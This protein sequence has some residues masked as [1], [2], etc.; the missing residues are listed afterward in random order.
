MTVLQVYFLKIAKKWGLRN[1]HTKSACFFPLYVLLTK[2]KSCY[3]LNSCVYYY[4][5]GNLNA[6]GFIFLFT[7]YVAAII[8][9]KGNASFQQHLDCLPKHMLGKKSKSHSSLLKQNDCRVCPSQETAWADSGPDN[10]T[11][12][13]AGPGLRGPTREQAAQEDASSCCCCCCSATSGSEEEV[14][15]GTE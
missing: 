6:N 9:L 14:E 3:L 10:Q 15:D 12:L 4:L 7:V 11:P 2:T 5:H 1:L 13:L 8:Y